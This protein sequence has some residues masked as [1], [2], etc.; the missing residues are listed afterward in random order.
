MKSKGQ[1]K[2][3]EDRKDLSDREIQMEILYACYIGY[4]TAE[5]TRQ[6]TSKLINLIVLG[7]IFSIIISFTLVMMG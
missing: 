3:E 5:R 1:L 2:F 6:N 7:I 4:K